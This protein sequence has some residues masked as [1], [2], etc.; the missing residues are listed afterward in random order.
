MP[1]ILIP[2]PTAAENHQE[3]N[4]RA[5]EKEGGCTVIL[6]KELNEKI[7]N[8]TIEKMLKSKK[9]NKIIEKENADEK[10]FKIIKPYLEG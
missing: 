8:S 7:L 5:Y 1:A 9:E 10:I 3:L 2:L 4:A 6:E